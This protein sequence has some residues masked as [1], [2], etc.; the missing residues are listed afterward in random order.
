MLLIELS[1]TSYELTIH[2]RDGPAGRSKADLTGHSMSAEWLISYQTTCPEV[3]VLVE[4][5]HDP[6]EFFAR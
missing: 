6:F 4:H 5:R 2:K 3:I 1:I